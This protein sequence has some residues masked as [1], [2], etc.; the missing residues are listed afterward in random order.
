LGLL[1][2]WAFGQTALL[3]AGI[4]LTALSLGLGGDV[5]AQQLPQFQ[6]TWLALLSGLSGGGLGEVGPAVTHILSGGWPLAWIIV[7]NLVLL[8]TIGVPY[9]SWM[10]SWWVR[11]QRQVGLS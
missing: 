6:G 4:V 5:V 11:R 1:G 7:L 8:V 10:A 9:W 2:T 3:V